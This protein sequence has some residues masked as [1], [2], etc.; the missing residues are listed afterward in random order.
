MRNFRV[1]DCVL[2]INAACEPALIGHVGIVTR[3]AEPV[4]GIDRFGRVVAGLYVVVDLPE[5]V[6][7][8]GTTL[9]YL[10]PEYLIKLKPDADLAAKLDPIS[11]IAG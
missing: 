3:A 7:R 8:H 10:P 9:W 6:N 2:V 5:N 4:S 11:E 1:G